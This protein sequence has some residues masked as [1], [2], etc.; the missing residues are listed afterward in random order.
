MHALSLVVDDCAVFSSC[1][2]DH[3]SVNGVAL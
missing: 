3:G 2:D 1:E